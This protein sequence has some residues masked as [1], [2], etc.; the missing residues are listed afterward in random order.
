MITVSSREFRDKQASYLDKVDAKETL[1]IHRGRKKAYLVVSIEDVDATTLLLS[2]KK[3]M[4][5][6]DDYNSGRDKG[7]AIEI[8]DLWK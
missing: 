7:V 3:L 2:D 5:A 1:I 8:D 4:K 6:L